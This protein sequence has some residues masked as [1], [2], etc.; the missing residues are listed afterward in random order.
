MPILP[1]AAIRPQCAL[2]YSLIECNAEADVGFLEWVTWQP[3]ENRGLTGEFYAY[4]N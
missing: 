3:D 4:V 1:N 2:A